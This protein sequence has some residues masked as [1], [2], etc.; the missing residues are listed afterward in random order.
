MKSV[1]LVRHKP[2]STQYLQTLIKSQ[3]AGDPQ[4]KPTNE[5][6]I[7][8]ITRGGRRAHFNSRSALE[9]EHR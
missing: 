2:K 1:P 4:K 7:V 8:I 6:A 9:R 3:S 5:K